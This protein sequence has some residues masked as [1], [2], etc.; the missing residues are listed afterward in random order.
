MIPVYSPQ[1]FV[2]LFLPN[3]NRLQPASLQSFLVASSME[4]MSYNIHANST[5]YCPLTVLPLDWD[6]ELPESV[7]NVR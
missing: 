1:T 5:L 3:P 6:Q 7:L 2:S 4:L